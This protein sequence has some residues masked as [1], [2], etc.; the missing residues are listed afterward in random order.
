MPVGR[1]QDGDA[2][3]LVDA[4]TD[5]LDQMCAFIS[6][7]VGEIQQR[8]LTLPP[9]DRGILLDELPSFR[10]VADER[11]ASLHDVR[12]APVCIEQ[13]EVTFGQSQ[14]L[15]HARLVGVP[16]VELLLG[17]H[18]HRHM[19]C[20]G[21]QC[22]V[23]A[24]VQI[25]PFINHHEVVEALGGRRHTGLLAHCQLDGL[26]VLVP[27]IVAPGQAFVDPIPVILAA[28]RVEGHHAIV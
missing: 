27:G 8:Q 19:L 6:H 7:T 15:R 4:G 11:G 21:C 26:I 20:N 28:P 5:H 22:F 1:K 12:R 2:L 14:R 24:P 3:V 25:L 16:L 18:E 17:I 9:F 13:H 10:L 23:I